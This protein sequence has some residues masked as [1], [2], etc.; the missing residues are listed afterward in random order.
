VK[1]IYV[2]GT[3]DTKG[4]ELQFLRERIVA[5]GGSPIVVDIGTKQATITADVTAREVAGHHPN[6]ADVPLGGNDRGAAV[7]SMGEAFSRFV[8]TRDDI[9]AVIGSAVAAGPRWSLP[10]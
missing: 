7:A 10:G 9:A 8:T 3:A 5:L 1:R 4:A 6:G 2:V